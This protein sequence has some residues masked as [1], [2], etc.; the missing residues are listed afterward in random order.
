MKEIPANNI[1][2]LKAGSKLVYNCYGRHWACVNEKISKICKNTRGSCLTF[3]E[4]GD[5]ENCH[6]AQQISVDTNRKAGC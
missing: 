3:Q 4:Y 6:E 1:D 2:F 5:E